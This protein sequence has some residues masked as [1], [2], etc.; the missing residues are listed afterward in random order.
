[1]ATHSLKGQKAKNGVAKP[2]LDPDYTKS[3]IGRYTK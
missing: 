1:M 2:K 3:L